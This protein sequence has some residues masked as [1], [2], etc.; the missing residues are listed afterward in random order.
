MKIVRK[1]YQEL[2][3]VEEILNKKKNRSKSKV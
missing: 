3:Q 2:A 1:K